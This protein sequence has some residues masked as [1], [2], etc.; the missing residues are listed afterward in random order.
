MV[1]PSHGRG[2]P[3]LSSLSNSCVLHRPHH[4]LAAQFMA[5]AISNAWSVP[6]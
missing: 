4:I 1:L 5:Y 3:V 2:L 6:V